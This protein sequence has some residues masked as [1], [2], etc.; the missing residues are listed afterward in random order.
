MAKPQNDETPP[1]LNSGE[2]AAQEPPAAPVPARTRAKRPPADP[3]RARARRTSVK[4]APR[5]CAGG[6]EIGETAKFCPECGARAV[7]PDAPPVCQNGHEV[8]ADARFCAM[9]GVSLTETV[10]EDRP[11]P[12]SELSEAEIEERKRMHAAAVRLGKENPAVA[13]Y[14]GK[15]PAAAATILIHVLVDGF[16]AFGHVWVRGQE[17]EVWEGHPRWAEMRAL[18]AQDT[19]VQ[20]RLYGRQMYGLGQ[21]PGERSYTAGAGKFEKLAAIGGQG[22]VP[23]PTE[24]ELARADDAE[25]RRSRRVPAPLG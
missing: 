7:D 17:L 24:E 20:F 11:R 13:Y 18:A 10:P 14:P 16:C 25:R 19:T 2:N 5:Q 23:E 15:A 22:T 6:H 9:C 12:E 1:K 4:K 3:A 8:P 21:W